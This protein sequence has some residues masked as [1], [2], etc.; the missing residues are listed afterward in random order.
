MRLLECNVCGG[1]TAVVLS[2]GRSLYLTQVD[3]SGPPWHRSHRLDSRILFGFY[4]CVFAT[5]A[6]CLQHHIIVSTAQKVSPTSLLP[7]QSLS[8]W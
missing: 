8:I 3:L 6:P 4:L 1:I 5:P 7:A 2:R